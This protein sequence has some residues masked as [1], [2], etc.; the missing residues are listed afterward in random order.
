MKTLFIECNMGAAGDMLMAAL[1]ELLPDKS[2]FLAKINSMGLPGVQVSAKPV[3]KSGITGTSVSVIARNT[4]EKSIDTDMEW[5]HLEGE[6]DN[7]HEHS[8]GCGHSHDH[9]HDSDCEHELL[10]NRKNDHHHTG[11]IEIEKILSDLHVSD[12]VKNDALKIYG[13]LAEAESLAHGRPVSEVHFHEVGALDAITDIVG[14]C[15]LMEELAPQRVIVSPVHVGSGFVHCAHGILPVPAP[16]TAH[17]LKNV[18]AFG[19]KIKGELCTPTGAALLKYFADDFDSMPRMRV[20]QIGYGMGKK[21]FEA[22]NC[23]RVFLGESS[24]QESREQALPVNGQFL[25]QNPTQSRSM[26]GSEAQP[27]HQIAELSCNIDDMTAEALAFTCQTLMNAGA[28]DVF[29]IA[30]GMKKNRPGVLLTCIC[31]VQKADTFAELML[32]FTTTFG[33]RKIVLDRYMLERK[34]KTAETPFGKVRV[35]TG[36]GYGTAKSKLEYDDV[37]AL[38]KEHNIPIHEMER[39]L[40]A[41]LEQSAL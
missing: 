21:D 1:L 38:A 37:A 39:K 12:N 15:M 4:E 25:E 26:A 18:P 35:K 9:E 32:K 28:L 2:A 14:V 22:V 24:L 16:A 8:H 19:G 23:V 34:V 11:L 29:F 10:H 40:W 31:D 33:V 30:T 41:H 7:E 6:H 17:I 20:E 5:L 36:T 3:T 27:N 13:L